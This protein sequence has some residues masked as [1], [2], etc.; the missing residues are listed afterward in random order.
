MTRTIEIRDGVKSLS[1]YFPTESNVRDL[2]VG[3]MAP[4]CFGGESLVTRINA[5]GRDPQGRWFV[6][7]HTALGLN[8]S[9]SNS[10]HQDTVCRTVRTSNAFTSAQIDE[11][12]RIA[13]LP[14]KEQVT[15]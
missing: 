11:A 6:H 9:V 10:L 2:K 4:D 15:L 8:G 7:Y 13:R 3:D 12:E 5:L 14:I 1:A